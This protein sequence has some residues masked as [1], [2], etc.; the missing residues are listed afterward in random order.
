MDDNPSDPVSDRMQALLS[1]AVEEQVSEQRAVSTAL[2]ELRGLV[3]GLGDAVR[4]CASEQSVDRLSDEVATVDMRPYL[5]TLAENLLAAYGFDEGRCDLVLELD[6]P[7]V[8]VDRAVPLGLILNELVTNALKHAYGQ[9]ARPLLRLHLSGPAGGLLLEVEDNGPG[10]APA[11]GRG[12]S[13]G[14]Q[15]ILALSEQIGGQVT[16]GNQPGAYFRLWVPAGATG[17]VVG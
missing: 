3:A 5:T 8:D 1:R 15:L 13:F 14:T 10:R 6:L 16:M 9:V 2:T 4:R 12:S 17:V 11:A 7:A